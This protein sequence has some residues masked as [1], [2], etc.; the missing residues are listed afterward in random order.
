MT[1][2]LASQTF[3]VTA[4]PYNAKDVEASGTGTAVSATGSA[5]NG[6]TGTTGKGTTRT[7]T[8]TGTILTGPVKTGA[9]RKAQG[10]TEVRNVGLLALLGMAV[11]L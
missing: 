1:W 10:V 2:T 5:S 7:T 6:A 11:M 4:A 3:T 9:A 8:A